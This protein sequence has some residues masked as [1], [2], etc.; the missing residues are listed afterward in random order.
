METSLNVCLVSEPSVRRKAKPK[1]LSAAL[2]KW[3]RFLGF[4]R[5]LAKECK[6]SRKCT[7]CR[8]LGALSQ[9]TDKPSLRKQRQGCRRGKKSDMAKMVGSWREMCRNPTEAKFLDM[10]RTSHDRDSRT[11]QVT[12]TRI[13]SA[14]EGSIRMAPGSVASPYGPMWPRQCQPVSGRSQRRVWN[15]ILALP[16]RRKSS[17]I[18]RARSIAG[19]SCGPIGRGRISL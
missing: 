14:L 19:L 16:R 12:S 15:R 13:R 3:G 2:D 5:D 6:A 18:R 9:G 1:D 10:V 8:R 4:R 7:D 17:P 11:C